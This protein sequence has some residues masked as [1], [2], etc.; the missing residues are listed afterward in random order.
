MT[1]SLDESH[2]DVV[3]AEYESDQR[4]LSDFCE[5]EQQ[6]TTIAV[7]SKPGKLTEYCDEWVPHLGMPEQYLKRY[8]QY[9]AG[10]KTNSAVDDPYRRAWIDAEL[11]K[12]YF[13]HVRTSEQAQKAISGIVSR[14]R[15]G[16]DITLVCFEKPS[17][18]CH[19]HLLI[20]MIEARLSSDYFNENREKP[21]TA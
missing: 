20:E 12:E 9:L 10:Y 1:G 14:L 2:I 19:R 17:Q 4:S 5:D 16:E 8:R 6:P 18:P 11:E 21:L 3:Q 13:R 15:D 7:V